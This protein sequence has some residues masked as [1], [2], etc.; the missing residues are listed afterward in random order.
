MRSTTA[1]RRRCTPEPRH[2]RPS[3][4]SRKGTE[5]PDRDERDSEPTTPH[6]T[7]AMG[8]KNDRLLSTGLDLVG[9]V[10]A[11]LCGVLENVSETWGSAV[12]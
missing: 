10:V 3:A 4:G 12:R 11:P 8:L 2:L 6:G 1:S 9:G 5:A 7:A